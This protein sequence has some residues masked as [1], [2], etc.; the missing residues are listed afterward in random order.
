MKKVLD[1]REYRKETHV[2]KY[3]AAPVSPHCAL[4]SNDYFDAW[5]RLDA[6]RRSLVCPGD[7]EKCN[8]RWIDGIL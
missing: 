5:K 2:K 8:E 1:L 6:D 3:T 7:H 4:W